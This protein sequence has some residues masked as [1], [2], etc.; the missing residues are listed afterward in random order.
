MKE[1]VSR[2]DEYRDM[3][4]RQQNLE[5]KKLF[6]LLPDHN[7]TFSLSDLGTG[8]D[9]LMQKMVRRID[10][11][12][13]ATS[14]QILEQLSELV[15]F[16]KIPEAFKSYILVNFEIDSQLG[17]RKQSKDSEGLP[18]PD[19]FD[20]YRKLFQWD[21]SESGGIFD[22]KTAP[23]ITKLA[24][25][26]AVRDQFSYM[27]A[28]NAEETPEEI[29]MGNLV[30]QLMESLSDEESEKLTAI[31]EKNQSRL[32]ELKKITELWGKEVV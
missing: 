25:R 10:N 12:G 24:Y 19:R 17:V 23:G 28:M 11:R 27:N 32:Q 29:F 1:R 7:A 21:N 22:E 5:M 30:R 31:A 4:P 26:L 15:F 8:E 16:A 13:R 3:S 2:K 6:D 20:D 14:G 18:Y 9:T